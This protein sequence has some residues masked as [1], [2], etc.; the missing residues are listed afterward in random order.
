[1]PYATLAFLAGTSTLFVLPSAPGTWV[2]TVLATVCLPL[3]ASRRWRWLGALGLGAALAWA[4]AAQVV[5]AAL[6]ADVLF[7]DVDT[8]GR[9]VGLPERRGDG[10]LRFRVS[11]DRWYPQPP[12]LRNAV[13]RAVLLTWYRDAPPIEA[14]QRWRLRVRLKPRHGMANPGGF[15][16]ARWLFAQRLAGTG[17]VRSGALVAPAP[18][19]PHPDRWRRRIGDWIDRQPYLRHGDLIKALA[20]GDRSGV[21]AATWNA[22]RAT[23]TAHLI[24]ISGLHIGFIA[25]VAYFALRR[26][27]RTLPPPAPLPAGVAAAWAGL[28]AALAYALLAGLTLPTRRAL[29]MVGLFMAGRILKRR[30]DVWRT[31]QLSLWAVLLLD[32]L[33]VLSAG[34]WLSFGAVACILA[35]TTRRF[36]AVS[37]WRRLAT[38]QLALA[39]GLAPVMVSGFQQ[40]PL[41]GPLANAVAVPVVGAVA[42]PLLLISLALAPLSGTLAALGLRAAD[43][44]LGGTALLLSGIA[45][46]PF[47]RWTFAVD[48]PVSLALMTAAAVL[49]L[50]PRGLPV[51]ACALALMLAV[52]ARAPPRPAAGDAWLTLLDVGQGLAAVIRTRAHTLVYD[53]GPRFPTGLDAGE[54]V[55]VPYLRH[56]RIERVDLLVVSHD[57]IDHIGGAPA[58]FDALDV[59]R[60]LSGT[61]GAIDWARSRRCAAGQRWHWDGVAFDM[62]APLT[63][64]AGNDASCV[65]KVTTARGRSL[66]LPGDS[67]APAE[68]RLVAAAG[69]ALRADVLI[70]PHHGSRT[71]S[72]PDFVERVDARL[73]LFPAGYANR[74]GFPKP[75]VVAR[76]RARGARTLIT[77]ESGAIGLQLNAGRVESL[78]GARPRVWRSA[79]S[80]RAEPFTV[81]P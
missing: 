15:D 36:G 58:L 20:V 18:D 31:F 56:A 19:N 9:I 78:R 23:G 6:P 64:A 22:L 45:A 74:F 7:R 2:W 29:I 71:S 47:G 65:L 70:A 80:G 55:L 50:A 44:L 5:R 41:L 21:S 59:R 30:V 62:L 61:P 4:Q 3:L 68:R 28:G 10:S 43:T 13:P 42:V 37:V 32:P 46:L 38:L 66:L 12:E 11:L 33:A 54:A 75:D 48:G 60:I 14:G 24:A 35:V 53:A 16:Y 34:F 39:V 79:P 40:V 49:V 51:R 1:M 8:E 81:Y 17:Y 57:D 27:C 67:E 25:G 72:T 76:Y 77:G 63:P 69:D 73:V 52:A 26:V